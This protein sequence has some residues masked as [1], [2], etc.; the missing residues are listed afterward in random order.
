MFPWL[1]RF[2]LYP[3]LKIPCSVDNWGMGAVFPEEPGRCFL[4]QKASCC[5]HTGITWQ[6]PT[7]SLVDVTLAEIMTHVTVVEAATLAAS[8]DGVTT[9]AAAPISRIGGERLWIHT[10]LDDLHNL[11]WIHVSR[12]LR[13]KLF[14]SYFIHWGQTT[15][16]VVSSTILFASPLFSV[17]FQQECK[18][19]TEIYL[20]GG[21]SL[22]RLC[23]ALVVADFTLLLQTAIFWK[24]IKN[25]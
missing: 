1:G 13:C 8:A 23:C 19:L 14:H 11:H 16:V 21:S 12:Q 20:A 18:L 25:I 4:K 9:T 15:H 2:F 24:Y 5:V 17:S 22:T 10:F 7:F 3:N 6:F